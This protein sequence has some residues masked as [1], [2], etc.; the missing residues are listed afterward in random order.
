MEAL[1]RPSRFAT[2]LWNETSQRSEVSTP[3]IIRLTPSDDI[4]SSVNQGSFFFTY[5][6]KQIV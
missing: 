6:G 5:K 3:K 4:I 1:G 2:R